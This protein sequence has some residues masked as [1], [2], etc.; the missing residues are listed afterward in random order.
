MFF[1]KRARIV[2]N[3]ANIVG[4][5]VGVI[6]VSNRGQLPE[7]F[8][9][10][11]YVLGFLL[12]YSSAV[13]KMS[14]DNQIKGHDLAIVLR[15][16]FLLMADA[17]AGLISQ[18]TKR[19]SKELNPE[20]I[21]GLGSGTVLYATSTGIIQDQQGLNDAKSAFK[22]GGMH[23]SERAASVFLNA[24][25]STPEQAS[26]ILHQHIWYEEVERRLIDRR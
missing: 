26:E 20:F 2:Q 5:M 13:A 21:E 6:R 25:K 1:W 12:S 7:G 22:S 3:V 24:I 11:P 23:W 4:P 19:Y 15:K 14:S 18:I 8:W 10:D 17:E 9:S 16:V